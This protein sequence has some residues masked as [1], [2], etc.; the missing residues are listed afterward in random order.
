MVKIDRPTGIPVH[1]RIIGR[2]ADHAG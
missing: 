1:S 2:Q